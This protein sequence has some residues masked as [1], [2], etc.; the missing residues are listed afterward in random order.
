MTFR[1]VDFTA[2]TNGTGLT[3]GSPLNSDAAIRAAGIVGGDVTYCTG[4]KNGTLDLGTVAGASTGPPALG[5]PAV[6]IGV[7]NLST[8]DRSSKVLINASGQS[9]ALTGSGNSIV[10]SGFDFRN[11]SSTPIQHSG[12]YCGIYNCVIHKGTG[13]ASIAASVYD[14]F[15]RKTGFY[16]FAGSGAVSLGGTYGSSVQDCRFEGCANPIYGAGYR[17]L[18]INNNVFVTVSGNAI[19]LPGNCAPGTTYA[20]QNNTFYGVTGHCINY[21][22]SGNNDVQILFNMFGDVTGTAVRIANSPSGT[23]IGVH[24]NRF[25]S[26]GTNLGANVNDLGGNE[27]LGTNPF[28]NAPTDLSLTLASGLRGIGFN[29]ESFGA[30]QI[31]A[32]GGGGGGI[33]GHGLDGGF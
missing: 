21:D 24:D 8:L 13:S 16:N 4:T 1:Y 15:F 10:M 32:G 17:N 23:N 11:S 6:F 22:G 27:T 18:T 29:G 20:I 12:S 31:G 30:Q 26:V 3:A 14:W 28:T 25:W 33:M 2:G 19:E 5:K 7:T 9:A